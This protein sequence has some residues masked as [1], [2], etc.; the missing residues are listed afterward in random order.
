MSNSKNQNKMVTINNFAPRKREDG[1]LFYVLELTSGVELIKSATTG[2]FYATAKKCTIPS[3]LSES[4]C[5]AMR[6]S[7]L[8]GSIQKVSCEPYDYIHKQTGEIMML[9]YR[10]EYVPEE[11]VVENLVH[12]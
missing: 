10:F 6:G 9:D 11:N 8:P 7:S 2:Q 12:A 5:L 3:T 4:A 1:S